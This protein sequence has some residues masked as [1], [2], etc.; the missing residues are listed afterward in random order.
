MNNI[1]IYST[2][3]LP[4]IAAVL[5]DIDDAEVRVVALDQLK[6]YAVLN[7]SL[8][9]IESI[10]AA[11]DTLMTNKFPC[12]VLFFGKTRRDITVR[13]EGFDFIENPDN[14]DELIVRV[15]ALLRIKKIKDKLETV[16]TTDD[17]TGLHNRKYLQERLEEE[18]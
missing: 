2:K 6:D 10:E 1:V 4:E 17:L 9:I 11:R 15:N 18:I 3:P 12:P 5:A 14:K 8:I 13:A 7:P 16:S